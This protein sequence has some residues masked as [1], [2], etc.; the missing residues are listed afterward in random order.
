MIDHATVCAIPYTGEAGSLQGAPE[1]G[2]DYE[3][4]HGGTAWEEMVN[5]ITE[6][7]SLHEQCISR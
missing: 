1:A 5:A 7:P 3:Q 6:V 4:N 2:G